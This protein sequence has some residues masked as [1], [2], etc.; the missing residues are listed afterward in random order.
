MGILPPAA[1]LWGGLQVPAHFL[2]EVAGEAAGSVGG[3]GTVSEDGH[4]MGRADGEPPAE[5]TGDA[6]RRW[7]SEEGGWAQ[8]C[9]L[10]PLS[11]PFTSGGQSPPG[12][13]TQR[14]HT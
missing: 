8:T 2:V 11:Y 12:P 1:G 10:L 14:R 3:W 13:P 6:G 5:E 4:L 7:K 9:C